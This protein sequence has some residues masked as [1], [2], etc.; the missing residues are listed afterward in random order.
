[1]R[2]RHC[3]ITPAVVRS[4]ARSALRQA[5]PWRDSGR[6]VPLDKLLDLLLLIAPLAAPLFAGVRRFAFGF[7][8]ETARQAVR[9]NLPDRDRLTGG[10]LDALYRFG[11]RRRRR[12]SWVVAL[13]EHRTPFYGDR[14]A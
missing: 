10:L 9:A 13:D 11:T 14:S 12:R 3:T 4:T 2:H 1:M 6:L 7:S 8:H 5:L